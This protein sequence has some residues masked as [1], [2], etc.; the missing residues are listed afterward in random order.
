M[1]CGKKSGRNFLGNSLARLTRDFPET[2]Q[3]RPRNVSEKSQKQHMKNVNTC[4]FKNSS[5]NLGNHFHIWSK[6]TI[7]FLELYKQRPSSSQIARLGNFG[8][9]L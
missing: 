1:C 4:S 9:C 8:A 5:L 3:K 2:S 7:F 6:V